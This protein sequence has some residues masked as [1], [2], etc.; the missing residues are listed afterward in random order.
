MSELYVK[1]E[2][3]SV[4][5]IDDLPIY[6]ENWKKNGSINVKE[7]DFIGKYLSDKKITYFLAGIFV[8]MACLFFRSAH[9]QIIRG[10]Y[11]R[12]VAESNRTREKPLLS[13]RGL[14]FDVKKRVLVNNLPYFDALIVPRDLKLKDEARKEQIKDIATVLQISEQDIDDKLSK[15]PK[16]FKYPIA[17]REDIDYEQAL[18]LT[19]KSNEAPGYYIETRYER[20]Y[21]WPHEFSHLIGYEGK[22]TEKEMETKG[23]EGYLLNDYLGKTGLESKYENILRG[24]YGLDSVEVDVSGQEKKVLTH[25]S[26]ENG[27]S[28]VLTID[29]EVQ[30]KCREILLN[31]LRKIN[32]SRGSLVMIN[33]QNGEIIAL[34]SYPD[35]DNNLFAKGI[36]TQDYKNLVEDENQPLFDRAVKG[37]YPSGSSI[38]MAV[39]L[40]A[41][42]EKLIT[43]KTTYL[44][45]GGLWLYERW[46]FPDWASAG[47]GATNVYK[48][49]AWSVNTFFYIIG[50]GYKDYKGLGP[51]GLEKYFK[52]FGFG[53]KSGIDLPGESAGLVPNPVWKMKTKN[54]AWYIGDT[55]HMAIGQGDVLVTPLQIANYTAAIANGGT[56]YQPHLVKE[57]FANKGSEEIIKPFILREKFI[58]PENISIIKKA[59]R[60]TVTLG[61][62]QALDDLTL[63][64][65]GKTGTAQWHS[66]KKPHAWF[67]GFAPYD[68][69]EV[70]ITIL[71]EEGGEGSAVSVPIAHD[72]LNWYFSEYKK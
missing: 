48:A 5:E 55:Y 40:G 52:L 53:E 51:E 29:S 39:A 66:E 24:Q 44:S 1:R 46:F 49:I 22:I 67:V 54:E 6:D 4:M 12:Q 20:E 37:E 7:S 43:D 19:I 15:Y 65:A 41:L 72:V 35:F 63:P 16:N 45:T 11:Y 2:Y 27:K 25:Q 9:L 47:H 56:L 57:I 36:S 59:M 31:T 62:A 8:V 18:L 32:K 17:V 13:T 58:D 71:V 30:K 33:P 70:A 61:S 42:Q 68:N 64:V 26:P 23:N 60:Q 69:P 34:I 28:L 21:L 3:R 14:I 10:G 38:K 50:G